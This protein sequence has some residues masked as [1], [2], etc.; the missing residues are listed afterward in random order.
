MRFND[1]I[2]DLL[3]EDTGN[4]LSLESNGRL[5][6]IGDTGYL[7]DFL[8]DYWKQQT[9]E[10]YKYSYNPLICT[11]YMYSTKWEPLLNGEWELYNLTGS[12]FTGYTWGI[13]GVYSGLILLMRLKRQ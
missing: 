9:I 5:I 8:G 10:G 7:E 6:K 3:S 12:K 13:L 2:K 11:P 1:I 4:Q